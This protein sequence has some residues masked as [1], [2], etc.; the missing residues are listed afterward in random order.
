MRA[1]WWSALLCC[2]SLLA[3]P[4]DPV[5]L[6]RT[7]CTST[8]L[9]RGRGGEQLIHAEFS[10]PKPLP[11]CEE[12]EQSLKAPPAHLLL[13]AGR[14]VSVIE[15]FC[16]TGHGASGIGEDGIEIVG[17]RLVLTRNGGA[18]DRWATG[19]TISLPQLRLLL[20]AHTSAWAGSEGEWMDEIHRDHRRLLL[21][22]QRTVAAD[23]AGAPDGEA[24][25]R[26]ALTVPRVGRI[27]AYDWRRHGLGNCA[28]HIDG[29]AR[30]DLAA[31]GFRI[32]GAGKGAE[33]RLLQLGDVG[34]V[35]EIRDPHWVRQGTEPLYADHLEL[36]FGPKVSRYDREAGY[37]AADRALV[38]WSI[39]PFD[40]SVAV[41]RGKPVTPIKAEAVALAD[42][43]RRV[44][45]ELP[46]ETHFTLVYSDSERGRRQDRLIATSEL[47]FGRAYSL[48]H[49]E[50]IDVYRPQGDGEACVLVGDRLRYRFEAGVPFELWRTGD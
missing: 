38:Q 45:I 21:F 44:R 7:D 43:V 20:S 24:K 37:Q 10:A 5:C 26:R 28:L 32:H 13:R 4:A 29:S 6:G 1:L 14:R 27:A 18:G 22:D 11:W 25:T 41:L 48:G 40:G 17:D 9:W 47:V 2:A 35:V 49:S 23:A 12:T 31:G 19:R 42:G 33:F 16:N 34:L 30:G 46:D 50:S 15:T 3:A 39:S 36:W 8:V